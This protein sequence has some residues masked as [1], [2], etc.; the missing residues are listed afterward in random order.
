MTDN[1]QIKP[2]DSSQA[3]EEKQ[4]A[5]ATKPKDPVRKWT[6]I[7]LTL[8]VLLVCWYLVSDRLTPY[9]SQARVHA[10]VVP[11]APEVSGTI[12]SVEVSNNQVVKAGQKLFTIDPER[13]QLAVQAAEADLQSARQAMGASTANVEAA[14]AA[15]VSAVA[16]LERAEKDAIRLRRIKQEDPG[17]ISE[18]RI[19]SAEATLAAARG[20]VDAAKANI[21][22]AKE[23]LGQEGER[24]SRILQA[25]SALAGARLNLER[26][27]VKAPEDG[28]VTDVRINTGNYANASA[29]QMTFVALNN[30]WIQADFTENNLGHIQPGNRVK[31]VFDALPG[32]IIEGAVREL[33]FG[34]AVDSAPLG[35]LPT[36]SNDQSW[37]RAAQRYPVLIDFVIDDRRETGKLRVGSQASV[38]VMTGDNSFF[39]AL[40]SL[41]I[42][43]NSI[44]TYAY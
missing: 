25:Q 11:V 39:N 18:R 34:V 3:D 27:V 44:L 1:D 37:L 5:P 43:L 38:V 8:T 15:L 13:Y 29:P 28:L 2:Q 19:E 10:L 6:F 24:N 14:E 16:G 42:W 30:I 22:K 40:A 23:D 7:L 33:G 17:A 32:K 26:T 9:T 4:A 21:D 20:Q 12:M 35:S 41:Q 31:I 36:I